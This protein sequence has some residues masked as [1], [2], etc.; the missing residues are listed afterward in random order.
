LTKVTIAR[1]KVTSALRQNGLGTGTR[2]SQLRVPLAFSS[3]YPPPL[4]SQLP[5]KPGLERYMISLAAERRQHDR[6]SSRD[7]LATRAAISVALRLRFPWSVA[8]SMN[9]RAGMLV[10]ENAAVPPQT[11]RDRHL[12]GSGPKRVL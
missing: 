8:Q 4:K 2:R 1:L 5:V 12:F 10:E 11:A 7:M 6:P 9:E 3:P